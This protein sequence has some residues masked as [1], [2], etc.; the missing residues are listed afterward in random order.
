MQQ[1][2][3]F[4]SAGSIGRVS[5]RRLSIPQGICSLGDQ[6]AEVPRPASN[7]N[8]GSVSTGCDTAAFDR[9]RFNAT[10][11]SLTSRASVSR[12]KNAKARLTSPAEKHARL[13]SDLCEH[14][15]RRRGNLSRASHKT[16]EL[17]NARDIGVKPI[18]DGSLRV[19]IGTGEKLE[20]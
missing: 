9:D 2:A 18:L 3:F 15:S 8:Y 14:C 20:P 12:R 5:R 7:R 6:L 10:D 4:A 19:A 16:I 13:A 17:R 1:T 11:P